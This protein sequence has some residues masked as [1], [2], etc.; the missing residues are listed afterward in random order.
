MKK[1]DVGQAITVLANLGVIAGIVF[2]AF[3]QRHNN[4]LIAAEGRINH[5]SLQRETWISVLNAYWK[6]SLLGAQ[7][8][9]RRAGTFDWG[10]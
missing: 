4:E 8:Q 3:E 1:S 7:W 9:F 2:L 6:S 5:V 10:P